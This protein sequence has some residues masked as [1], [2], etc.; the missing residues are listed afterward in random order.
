MAEHP[1][2]AIFL[3]G[4]YGVGKTSVLDHVGNLLAARGRPFSLMDVDWFHRSWPVADDDPDNTLVEARAIAAVWAAYRS[5]GPRQLVLS[6]V[7]ASASDAARYARAVGMPIRSVRLVAAP[8]TLEARLRRRY[9]PDR[10]ED[11]AWHRERHAEL[12]DRQARADLDEAVIDAD[13]STSA[14]VARR[15]LRHFGLDDASPAPR[16]SADV[17]GSYAARTAEYAELL[18][19]MAAVHPSDVELVTTWAAGVTGPVLDAGCGP[20]HWTD[21]LARRGSDVRGIDQVA[22]FVDHA[23]AAYPAVP[24]AT[25]SI[26][27]LPDADGAYGGVLAWYSLIHHEPSTIR[28]ALDEIA[29][30]LRP[31]GRLLVGFFVGARLEAFD[32]AVVTAY[33]WPADLLAG[34]LVAAGFEV[35][36]THTRTGDAAGP[37]PHGAISARLAG[38]R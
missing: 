11:L 33:R 27:A 29:R 15:V 24:F 16:R 17:A 30:V 31:D 5:V 32:H 35:V 26:D 23:R 20:G 38:G 18:G 12:A 34:E 10:A 37:R 7:I 14:E 1:E 2:Y 3:N 22:A 28:R 9:D 21:H 6:G 25:G 36:E 4:S 8:R 19:S 13:D